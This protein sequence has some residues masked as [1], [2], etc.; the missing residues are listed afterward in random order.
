MIHLFFNQTRY[1]K[2]VD[3]YNLLQ[4]YMIIKTHFYS[5]SLIAFVLRFGNG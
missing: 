2:F 5:H 4:P 1:T 3:L